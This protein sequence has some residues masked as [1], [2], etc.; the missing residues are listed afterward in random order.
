M[1]KKPFLTVLLIFTLSSFSFA[2]MK[3][4]RFCQVS[5]EPKNKNGFTS[6]TVAIISFGEVD[7]LFFFKDSC[8]LKKLKQ[9]NELTTSIDVL[10]YMSNIGWTFVSVIP[11]GLYT[12]HERIYFR[13][14]FEAT[15]LG[16]KN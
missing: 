13:K 1:K 3:I 16:V 7:S 6:K 9:V 15:D 8:I 11:F 12:S 10:N 5:I 2:Q 4:D 14:T